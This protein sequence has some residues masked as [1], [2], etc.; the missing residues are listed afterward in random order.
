MPF[1]NPPVLE[2]RLFI[3]GFSCNTML[4]QYYIT[5]SWEYLSVQTYDVNIII[6]F[7]TVY[8]IHFLQAQ[9]SLAKLLITFFV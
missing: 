5:M 7:V 3:H 6:L 2:S 8:F 9:V 4:C 1:I